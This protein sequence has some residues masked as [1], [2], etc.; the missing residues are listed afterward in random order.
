MTQPK[1]TDEKALPLNKVIQGDCFE[2]M[3]TLPDKCIDLVLTD[4]PYS[5]S[6][7]H[8]GLRE[9]DYGEWDKDI[10]PELVSSWVEQMARITKGSVCVFCGD[11]QFSNI[12]NQLKDLGFIVRKY[13]W[14]KTNPSVMNGQHFWLSSGELCVCAKRPQSYYNGNCEKAYKISKSPTDRLHPTQKPIE[15]MEELIMRSCPV[16]GVVLDPFAGSGTTAV[17]CHNL[18]RKYIC[19]EKEPKY[20]QIC[21]DRIG[22]LS[23][24]LFNPTQ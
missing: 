12:F 13:Q 8:G 19:I 23:N 11:G 20:V 1:S 17:A 5:I 7:E 4:I 9:I 24:S 3:R 6:Q 22:A 14:L 10:S 18:N 15:I 2:V 16:G 21:N